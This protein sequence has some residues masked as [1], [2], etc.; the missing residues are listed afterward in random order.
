LAAAT[1]HLLPRP[2][3]D[4]SEAS[5]CSRGIHAGFDNQ[6]GA[7]SSEQANDHCGT[8]LPAHDDFE[9]GHFLSN[10]DERQGGEG[11]YENSAI[12]PS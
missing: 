1:H 10:A 2:D 3:L 9:Q 12:M 11:K 7:G 6:S 5:H 8:R 4:R